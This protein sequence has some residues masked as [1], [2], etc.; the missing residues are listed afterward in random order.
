MRIADGACD[1]CLRRAALLGR[2]A[3]YIERVA[4]GEPGRRCAELL[5]NDAPGL[6]RAVAP[7]RSAELL[8][9]LDEGVPALRAELEAR[10]CWALCR[11]DPT[12]PEPLRD[13]EREAPHALLGRGR[14]ELIAELELDRTVTIVGARRA[15]GYGAGVARELARMLAGAGL[16]VVSGL[17]FGIDSAAH[18]GALSAGCETLAVLGSG[19]DRAYPRARAALYR[20]IVAHGAVVSELPPGTSPFRWTFPARN[21]IMAA[22]GRMT[23]VVEAAERSGSLI[24]ATMAQDLDREV[25]AVP[26]PVNAWLSEGTNQLLCDGARL[27]RDA[28]DV[29]DAMLGVGRRSVERTGPP[30]EPELVTVLSRVDDEHATLDSIDATLELAPG[31][32]AAALARL[33]LLGYVSSDAAGRYA[34]T[35]L[36]PP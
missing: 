29:L 35:S 5:A 32:T 7:E 18:E 24:T 15:S 19:P 9:G 12:Y 1:E 26:G 4:T 30:L 33:E 23:I 10:D 20:E 31:R 21:R 3:P 22:L 28:Q 17:A 13:L 34:R 25:G 16:A 14:P 6:I 2:L 36:R 11:H 8:T 27:V